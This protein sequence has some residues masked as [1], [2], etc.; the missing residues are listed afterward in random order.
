MN[1]GCQKFIV[2]NLFLKHRVLVFLLLMVLT[3]VPSANSENALI[4]AEY[5]DNLLL[6]IDELKI[7]DP[8]A[9]DTKFN[10]L[11]SLKQQASQA[12]LDFIRYFEVYQLVAQGNF[13][14][15]QSEYKL[16]FDE[17]SDP[18]VKIRIKATLSNLQAISRQ[19]NE[20]L[21][22]LDYAITNIENSQDKII[23]SKIHFVTA[24]V[25]HLLDIHDMSVKYAE[26]VIKDALNDIYL[27]KANAIKL[28]SEFKSGELVEQQN[29]HENIALCRANNQLGY[30]L[31]LTLDWIQNELVG[32]QNQGDLNNI[33]LLKKF[34]EDL[35]NEIDGTESKNLIGLKEMLL[36]KIYLA[37]GLDTEAEKHATL[38]IE[39]S[40]NNGNTLQVVESLKVLNGLA[41]KNNDFKMAYEYM[42]QINRVENEIFS[43]AKAKQMA[44]M[45]VKHENLAKQL[46]IEQLNQNNQL[47]SLENKLAAETSKKQQL[48]MLLVVSLL[49]LLA[50]WTYRIKKKRDYFKQV[51][52]IDHLTQVFTRK[53]FE[54]KVKVMLDACAAKNQPLNLAIM[55]LDHFKTVNDQYGHLVGDWVL[56]QVILTCEEVA[57]QDILV[58]RLGG[59]E[60]CIV[61]PQITQ[62]EMTQL[63]ERMRLAI[64]QM[65]CSGSGSEFTITASF[66]VSSSLR[67]G[68]EVSMLL[69][70]A[71]VALFEAKNKGRN[72]VVVFDE[73]KQQSS[74]A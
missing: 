48:M 9:F 18:M 34:L 64:E 49:V 12:Q 29:V 24:N 60:F 25:Y 16:L 41:L 5:I 28:G 20:A 10:E 57:N 66:G 30:A 55:D 31:I 45:S 6:K 44:F 33:S 71:D 32:F 47:L 11:Q 15:A 74:A 59:E 21:I 26:L 65:D 3:Q 23:R 36:A 62:L 22:N 1:S 56:K 67:S 58:A 17:V 50:L 19:Y 69:T 40:S 13:D 27:C 63:V 70:H 37:L 52:E 42:S 4:S 61:S 38:A 51:A 39:G 68:Y 14:K 43:E 8:D 72:R 54:E 2:Q 46:E 35:E 53:A 73:I 7:S